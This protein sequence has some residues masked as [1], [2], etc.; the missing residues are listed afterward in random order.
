[1]RTNPRDVPY[2][3]K[4]SAKQRARIGKDETYFLQPQN[5]RI[6]ISIA[7]C[8]NVKQF[9]FLITFSNRLL[10]IDGHFTH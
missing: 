1:L 4:G 9:A 6:L 8:V 2:S 3:G 10:L 5:G 7:A